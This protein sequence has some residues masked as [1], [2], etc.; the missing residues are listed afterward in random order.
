MTHWQT[1]AQKLERELLENPSMSS[2]LHDLELEHLWVLYPGDRDYRLAP[3][4][5]VLS[6]AGM[7][8]Q[9]PYP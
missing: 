7:P 4:V 8:A 6:L 2:A 3:K 5:T 9:W 1:Q